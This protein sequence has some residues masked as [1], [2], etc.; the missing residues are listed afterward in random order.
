MILSCLAISKVVLEASFSACI[1]LKD[2]SI[3][4]DCRGKLETH[5]KYGA[6]SRWKTPEFGN[7]IKLKLRFL[8]KTE[9]ERGDSFFIFYCLGW[10][11]WNA[12]L[13]REQMF[14]FEKKRCVSSPSGLISSLSDSLISLE[15]FQGQSRVRS[16]QKQPGSALS[17]S[18][19]PE[20]APCR[21]EGPERWHKANY[22]NRAAHIH[23]G[24][25][26]RNGNFA[27]FLKGLQSPFSL[28]TV[29]K[30]TYPEPWYFQPSMGG[31]N[32]NK[33]HSR[34]ITYPGSFQ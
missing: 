30:G 31:T 19:P 5:P 26:L 11:L 1:F 15:L 20:A 2:T 25:F 17:S 9:G 24:N 18:R 14:T 34:P 23:P 32:G 16:P 29:P 12:F 33:L 27:S 13:D 4:K 22:G 7:L 10:A 3:H 8:K 21:S 6:E 28:E